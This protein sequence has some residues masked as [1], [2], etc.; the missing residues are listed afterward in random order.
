MNVVDLPPK[1]QQHAGHKEL[2]PVRVGR[3]VGS[4]LFW[5]LV[6]FVAASATLSIVTQVFPTLAKQPLHTEARARCG[7]Q[8]PEL[9]DA[10]LDRARDVPHVD[11]KAGLKEWFATWDTRFH[12]LGSHCGELEQTRIELQRLR[13]SVHAMLSRFERRE[14]PRLERIQ[15]AIDEYA[16]S[17]AE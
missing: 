15:R 6:V 2:S 8:I 4:S 1:T 11:G 16:T 13:D 14:T 5:V 10:L 3:I 17:R 12:A 9:R 7:T